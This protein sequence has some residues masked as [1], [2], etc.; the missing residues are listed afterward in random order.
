[1]QFIMLTDKL[2]KMRNSFKINKFYKNPCQTPPPPTVTESVN[3]WAPTGW[4]N[5]SKLDPNNNK[6]KILLGSSCKERVFFGSNSAVLAF[7]KNSKLFSK[8]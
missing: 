4:T 1:M 5:W 2:L 7:T 6:K 3:N 8:S